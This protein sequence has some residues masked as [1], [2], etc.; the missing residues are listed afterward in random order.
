MSNINKINNYNDER[1]QDKTINIYE[2]HDDNDDDIVNYDF[3]NYLKEQ[4]EKLVEQNN[5]LTVENK[6]LKQQILK[7]KEYF[8]GLRKAY[9]LLEK[10]NLKLKE[11][12]LKLYNENY[13][14]QQKI[15][16]LY[17]LQQKINKLQFQI[18]QNKKNEQLPPIIKTR[19]MASNNQNTKQIKIQN[20]KN[21]ASRIKITP[22]NSSYRRDACEL[23]NKQPKYYDKMSLDNQKNEYGF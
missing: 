1:L 6:R 11:D 8:N 10:N 20:K 7:Y 21:S 16:K 14:L 2:H 13:G 19:N 4:N 15:D 3:D 5:N 17:G 23:N 12:N 18:E 22:I 9:S